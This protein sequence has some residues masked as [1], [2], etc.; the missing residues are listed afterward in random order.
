MGVIL[1][2]QRTQGIIAEAGVSS[3]TLN[4][5]ALKCKTRLE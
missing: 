5:A 2:T 3:N 1:L 4:T